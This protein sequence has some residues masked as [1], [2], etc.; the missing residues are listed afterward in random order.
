MT[1][2]KIRRKRSC[3]DSCAPLGSILSKVFGVNNWR[4]YWCFYVKL[5]QINYSNQNGCCRVSHVEGFV[6][7][8]QSRTWIC[9]N[10]KTSKRLSTIMDWSNGSTVG[11]HFGIG[12]VVVKFLILVT[13]WSWLVDSSRVVT[14]N[15][16]SGVFVLWRFS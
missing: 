6:E 9:A 14:W 15:S 4:S 2:R 7:K 1:L 8:N 3:C 12:R 5:L 11:W 10:E 16:P 13:T